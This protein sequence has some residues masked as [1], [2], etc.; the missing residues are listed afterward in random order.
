M[1]HFFRTLKH[2]INGDKQTL[3]ESI[4]YVEVQTILGRLPEDISIRIDYYGAGNALVPVT[5]KKQ[6]PDDVSTFVKEQL[7]Y[8][9]G[10]GNHR[11]YN[12]SGKET[13]EKHY[14]DLI[15]NLPKV[16]MGQTEIKLP[17]DK[18]ITLSYFKK[19]D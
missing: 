9:Y 13:I 8:M 2:S 16:R 4:K 12:L 15:G 14:L 3:D 7:S 17:P 11:I 6:S 10:C 19:A 1:A 18:R 5:F